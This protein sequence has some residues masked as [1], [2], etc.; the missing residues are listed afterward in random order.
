MVKIQKAFPDISLF[1]AG[2]YHVAAD[3]GG[4]LPE[5]TV[6]QHLFHSFRE[7]FDILRRD[8]KAVYSVGDYL[9]GPLDVPSRFLWHWVHII[10]K[11][12]D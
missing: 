5:I 3:G 9:A 8:H 1:E 2:G 7:C 6:N 11:W 12:S 4:S 10:L